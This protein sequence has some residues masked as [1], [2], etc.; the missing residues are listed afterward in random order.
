MDNVTEKTITMA[1]EGDIDSFETI[2]NEYSGL[3]HNVAFRIVRNSDEAQ[4]VT[5][6][7]FLAVYR[8]LKTFKFQSS[9]KTWIYRIAVNFALN[10]AK[11]ELRN[12][13]STVEFNN[14]TPLN[15]AIDSI[16][17]TIEKEQHEKKISTL[18]EA[19]NP[20]QRACI[21]LRSLEGLSY[22][23]IADSLNINV[24]TVRSRLK[25]AREKLVTLREEMV[26][27]EM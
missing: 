6:E 13:G 19:L 25:R 2:Y 20:D 27:N 7:V 17:E 14:N 10:Y 23:E 22:Q 15:K 1:S 21:V 24:N 18:L 5:Q 9:F 12:Q 26:K 8:K 3:V 16:D 11:K 4:E